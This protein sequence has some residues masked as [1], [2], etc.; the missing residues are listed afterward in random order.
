MDPWNLKK[1]K[2]IL[3]NTQDRIK[4]EKYNEH[5]DKLEIEYQNKCNSL[6]PAYLAGSSWYVGP[7]IKKY[8]LNDN[9]VSFNVLKTLSIGSIINFVKESKNYNN[10]NSLK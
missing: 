10:P 3:E 4:K 8:I 1:Y 2:K 6:S 7:S 9:S 5:L